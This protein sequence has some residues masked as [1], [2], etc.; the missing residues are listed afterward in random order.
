MM[1]KDFYQLHLKLGKAFEKEAYNLAKKAKNLKGKTEEVKFRIAIGRLY[2]GILHQVIY[3]LKTQQNILIKKRE[4]GKI[5]AIVR[6][7]LKE[8]DP[9]ASKNLKLL[10]DLR[11]EADYEPENFISYGD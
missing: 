7:R 1:G 10:H 3:W 4:R 8:I 5:H 11:K 9:I 2:Y 6:E